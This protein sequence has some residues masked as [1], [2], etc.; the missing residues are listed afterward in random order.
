M[1]EA[2]ADLRLPQ[3]IDPSWR[4]GI[5]HSSYYKEEV[6]V[7]V[8]SAKSELLSAGIKEENITLHPTAGSFE[9]PLIGSVLAKNNN[10]DALIGFGIIVEGETHHA[11]LVAENVARGIMD[12]QLETGIP[13]AFEVLYVHT[14]LQAQERVQGEENRG[15]EA[16]NAVISS[17]AQLHTMR[18]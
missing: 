3:K 1:K 9:I 7:M 15:K 10:V 17:L 13:F 11:H 6:Y 18:S 16:A 12:I 2:H 5:V 8:K 14:L 4:I